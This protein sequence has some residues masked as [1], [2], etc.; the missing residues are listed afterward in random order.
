M[1]P[2]GLADSV[3]SVRF[4]DRVPLGEDELSGGAP[5]LTHAE[6]Q[7][8]IYIDFERPKGSPANP[9]RPALLGILVGAADEE[10]EQLIVDERLASAVSANRSRCRVATLDSAVAELMDRATAEKRRIV[11]WSNFDRDR[12]VEACPGRTAEINERY[13]N[14]LSTARRWARAI[15]PASSIVRAAPRSPRHTLDQYAR[16]ADY[17]Q[18]ARI[19]GGRPAH[20]I[21]ATLNR[22]AGS[23][24][25]YRSLS[26]VGKRDWHHLLEYNR[27][28]C[29]AL[30]HVALRA[31]R[32]LECW[33]AYERTTFVVIENGREIGFRVGSPAPSLAALMKRHGATRSAFMTAWNPASVSLTPRENDKRQRS[34]R[35]K[36]EAAG[37]RWLPGEGRGDDV[38]WA[39]EDSLLVLGISEGKAVS[40]GRQ[41][42]QLAIVVA[43][44]GKPARLVSC[45]P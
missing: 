22:L 16:L 17:P 20:W 41:F 29:L 37:Y 32:E 39:P 2:G 18:T 7:R 15:H 33:E 4:A 35:G 28:D 5:R 36:I 45:V 34:L 1:R 43:R 19:A 31:A 21:T 40:L 23:G 11:G 42:G 38:S 9:A 12:L 24:G 27:H 10:L 13:V 26:R 30:R 8:A 6:A 44:V 3:R 14:P 25:R